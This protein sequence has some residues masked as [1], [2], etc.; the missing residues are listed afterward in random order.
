MQIIL[1]LFGNIL[2]L[3]SVSVTPVQW[4]RIEFGF[5]RTALKSLRNQLARCSGQSADITVNR[6][7]QEIVRKYLL[8]ALIAH[9]VE[10]CTM[11]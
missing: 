9:L 1:V 6:F 3:A 10:W 7:D 4:R 11:Y 2:R 8:G 5:M